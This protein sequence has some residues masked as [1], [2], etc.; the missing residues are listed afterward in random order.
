MP[1]VQLEEQSDPE[2]LIKQ[3]EALDWDGGPWDVVVQLN[4]SG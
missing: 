4:E 1:R 2:Q 3:I